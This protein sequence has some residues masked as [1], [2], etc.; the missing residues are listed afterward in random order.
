MSEPGRRSARLETWRERLAMA[1][2][3]ECGPD[4]L[5]RGCQ[6]AL[7]ERLLRLMVAARK[8]VVDPRVGT[9]GL[10]PARLLVEDSLQLMRLAVEA[11]RESGSAGPSIVQFELIQELVSDVEARLRIA[12]DQRLLVDR[13]SQDVEL[14]HRVFLQLQSARTPR[15]SLI[16]EL[17]D[18]WAC[19]LQATDASRPSLLLPG[20]SPVACQSGERRSLAW[21]YVE[22][23]ESARRAAPAIRDASGLRPDERR[24]V[25][26]ALLLRDAGWLRLIPPGRRLAAPLVEHELRRRA[27]RHPGTSAALV[28]GVA[29][30]PRRLPL[31]V[32]QHHERLDGSGYPGGLAGHVL[33]PLSRWV[34]TTTRF[35]EILTSRFR[36]AEISPD[37][38]LQQTGAE[39]WREALRGRLDQSVAERLLEALQPGLTRSVSAAVEESLRAELDSAHRL[40]GPHSPGMAAPR[41]DE[42]AVSRGDATVPEPKFLRQQRGGAAF[43]V[44]LAPGA[45]RRLE[46]AG[47]L[48]TSDTAPETSPRGAGR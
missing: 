4:R 27:M 35:Q 37:D 9:P 18:R 46:A 23:L 40:A 44:P 33:C 32:G 48:T 2:A 5:D 16:W 17:A 12:E 25:L 8:L 36:Q 3:T 29:D 13:L 39:V 15:S 22:S 24:L 19:P 14:L 20:V 42:S 47:E 38:A 6:E 11:L 30:I 1:A 7:H 43:Y 41:P 26:S 34:L 31:I 45:R 28:A 21:F 10:Q